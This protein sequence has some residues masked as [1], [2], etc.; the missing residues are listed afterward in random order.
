M[1]SARLQSTA[2]GSKPKPRIDNQKS[3]N[4][5][6]SKT[7]TSINVQEEQTLDLNAG[8]PFNLKKERIKV[9]IKENVISGK[10]R[11]HGI[12]LIQKISARQK[13]HGIR[14]GSLLQPPST[15][16]NA[17][18]SL[19]QEINKLSQVRLYGGGGIPFQLKSDSLP[20]AH[21]QTTKTYY[22]HQDSRIKK[23]QELKTKTSA[24]SDN[25]PSSETK[26]RGDY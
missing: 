20:H 5:P 10:P 12:T 9:W 13:S 19:E 7:S 21:A 16:K 22:K 2:N 25:D 26:L 23:A 18:L 24:N 8:T 11:L 15:K 14:C 17:L 6:A 1:P 3:R 4:W